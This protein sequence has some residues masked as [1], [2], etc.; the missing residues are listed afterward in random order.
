MSSGRAGSTGSVN[1]VSG[2]SPAG[3]GGGSGY[4]DEQVTEYVETPPD[5]GNFVETVVGYQSF[6]QGAS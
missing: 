5:S 3:G 1:A 4:D 6:T 2:A